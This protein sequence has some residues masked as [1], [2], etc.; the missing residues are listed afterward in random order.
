MNLENIFKKLRHLIFQIPKLLGYFPNV[1][2]DRFMGI[3]YKLYH[4][5]CPS[6]PKSI[7]SLNL[8]AFLLNHV[9]T[10]F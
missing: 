3:G 10:L 4:K 2:P 8:F 9:E 5:R 6:N 7:V 1:M